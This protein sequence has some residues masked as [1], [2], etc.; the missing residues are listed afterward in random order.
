MD[1]N[2]QAQVPRSVNA[3]GPRLMQP[4]AAN[5]NNGN[6]GNNTGR[7]SEPWRMFKGMHVK[8]GLRHSCVLAVFEFVLMGEENALPA[9]NLLCWGWNR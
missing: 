5:G 1:K 7:L 9:N 2:G 8:N 6:D 3:I 4:A